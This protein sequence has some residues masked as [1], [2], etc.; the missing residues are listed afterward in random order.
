MPNQFPIG[1]YVLKNVNILEHVLNIP[2]SFSHCNHL[3]DRDGVRQL[4]FILIHCF[5][6]WSLWLFG[7][8]VLLQSRAAGM[9]WAALLGFVCRRQRELEYA[10][11]SQLAPFSLLC[12][13]GPNEMMALTFT[14]SFPPSVDLPRKH[15]V[16]HTHRSALAKLLSDSQFCQVDN[17][18]QA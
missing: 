18:N 9:V 2:T 3:L 8:H 7:L 5:R 4:G 17:Q 12:C 11:V 10:G 14:V 15:S 6:E 1:R 13:L 16:R